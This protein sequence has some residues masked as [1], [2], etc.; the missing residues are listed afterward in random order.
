[1]Q[2]PLQPAF[3][4]VQA[5]LPD[6]LPDSLRRFLF[7]GG[8]LSTIV[9]GRSALDL[10]FLRIGGPAEARRFLTRYGFDLD[11]PANRQEL[12]RIRAEAIGFIRG[13]LLHGTD[14]EMPGTFDEIP[15]IDLLMMAAR[16]P[17]AGSHAEQVE[18]AWACAALRVMHTVAHAENYFQTHFY[19]EIR[20]AILERFVDQVQTAADGS[21]VLRG[22]TCDVPLV[23]FEV[24]E[25]KPLRSAVLKL[26]Q[27]EENVAYDL[28]DHIGVRIIVPR[29][30]DALFAVRALHEEH[31]IMYPNI[32]PTRSRNTLID[33]ERFG[34]EIGEVLSA[35]ESGEISEAAAAGRLANADFRPSTDPQVQWNPH[36]SDKY[37]AIQFTCRQLIRFA[38]PL[39]QRMQQ[40]QEAVCRKLEGPLLVELLG[41][42]DLFG[43][44]PEIQFFFPYEVQIMDRAS[45]DNASKGRAAYNEYKQRQVATARRRV[46]PRVL[47][48]TGRS[49][50]MGFGPVQQH[51]HKRR[52]VRRMLGQTLHGEFAAGAARRQSGN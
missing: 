37:N 46:M 52:P 10:T 8:T 41:T 27:K 26:L 33:I 40:A 7:S 1:M 20:A 39:Y 3:P 12:E 6:S 2:E 13:V 31:T 29:P 47:S 48:L 45:F 32:K 44:D 23:R 9:G 38:N 30:A 43:I 35:W 21:Q 17:D 11:R 15:P 4:E 18:Q 50:D 42:L 5:G 28:F 36:S 51:P 49:P 34:D 19:P 22:R 24:K 25:A 14:L 16:L